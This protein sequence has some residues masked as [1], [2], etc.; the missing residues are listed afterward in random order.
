MEHEA[1][2]DD[3]NAFSRHG[4]A[5]MLGYDGEQAVAALLHRKGFKVQTVGHQYFDILVNDAVTVEV[6]TALPTKGSHRN[7]QRWQFILYKRG[8]GYP[9]EEHVLILR[10]QSDIDGGKL[11]HFVI[12]GD[13][14]GIGKL[15]KIDITSEPG[16]YKGKWAQYL[17]NW[18]VLHR[19]TYEADRDGWPN[20][21]K[22]EIPF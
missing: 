9:L 14:P 5:N 3:M 20:P 21:L 16:K 6:K 12:P 7:K 4:A 15:T 2:R 11:W 19:I 1:R 17:E 13:V 10:C 22:Q 8:D 18:D